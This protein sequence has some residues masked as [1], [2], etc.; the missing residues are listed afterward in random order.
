MF[1]I[2]KFNHKSPINWDSTKT[3]LTSIFTIWVVS[4]IPKIRTNHNHNFTQQRVFFLLLQNFYCWERII[5]IQIWRLAPVAN[6]WPFALKFK[7]QEKEPNSNWLKNTWHNNPRNMA[8]NLDLVEE[9]LRWKHKP[10]YAHQK[11][12]QYPCQKGPSGH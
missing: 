6:Y 5:V 2:N 7:F 12:Q 3:S 11:G 8:L 4:W 10:G 1:L 9:N